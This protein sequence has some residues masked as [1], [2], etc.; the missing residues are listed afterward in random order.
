M[1]NAEF[2]EALKLL[3]KEKGIPGDYLLEK[4]RAAIIIAVKRDFG[5]KENIVVV[6]EPATG[7]FN[8]S[9]HKTVVEEVL[10]PDEEM[11]LD[12]ALRYKKNAKIGDVVEIQLETK[13]F[14][15]IAAQTAKHVIRQGIREAER[16]QQL[17]EF[18]RRNQELV[19]ALVTRVDA[20][21]GAATLEIGK[22]E[23]VLPKSE[24]LGEEELH[25]GDRIKV[26]VVDVREGDKG[27]R[28][29]ISRTHPGL[30][31]RLFE[32]EV[33]EIFNGVVEIK[34]VSR[35]AGSRT[36]LAVLSHDENVD[37]VGACI[38]P[39]GARV[40]GIVDE[41]GGEKIDIVEY[42]EEP[43]KFIA[44][45]LSPAKVLSVEVDP[46]GAKSSRVTV[47]DAQLSLA[48]GNKGQNAR[49][50][51]KLTGWKIDIRPES[52]FYGED[53]ENA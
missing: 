28:A 27:P 36:K 18:Q 46:E 11:T 34:A 37:A 49:L 45:A 26:Y 31:K 13:Q 16:G 39:R 3:E 20:K 10:D 4:I 8:V 19:T 24:Q 29:L 47:P 32:M 50:A 15:R 14:G 6:M 53:E 40:A 9:L 48:I 2:F 38:G 21:T 43:E 5:G 1:N 7:E 51:A 22:A 52:G 33:P 41:L 35:E 42:S 30:V 12:E 23:A 25:E 44:A 17:Q